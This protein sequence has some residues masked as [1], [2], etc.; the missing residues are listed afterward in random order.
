MQPSDGRLQAESDRLEI[1]RSPTRTR[2]GRRLSLVYALL[3]LGVASPSY[4][5]DITGLW[6]VQ[7]GDAQVRI[8]PCDDALCGRIVWLEEPLDEQGNERRDVNNNDPELQQ[9][10][11]VGLRIL[12]RVT[13]TQNEDGVWK[14]GRIY[15]PKNGKTYKCNI[16]LE[17][18]GRLKLRGYVGF[19]LFG[20]TSRWTR[21][22][23]Q[24]PPGD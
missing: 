15:D 2:P 14:D 23:D 12:E 21:V 6:L 7:E 19:S 5:D 20:R 8:E 17:P 11:V 4:A 24:V 22:T 16:E 10:T 1:M 13:A 3:C 18:D 9:R